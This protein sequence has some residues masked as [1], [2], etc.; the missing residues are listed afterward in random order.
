MGI[1]IYLYNIY[2]FTPVGG[3][4]KNFPIFDLPKPIFSAP[5]ARSS[6]IFMRFRQKK[7]FQI[8]LKKINKIFDSRIE[9]NC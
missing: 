4:L 8:I 7:Q 1:Y 2:P 6:T 5:A 9:N 3:E